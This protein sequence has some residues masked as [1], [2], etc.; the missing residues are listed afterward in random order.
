MS[1]SEKSVL[2][3]RDAPVGY[4]P[5]IFVKYEDVQTLDAALKPLTTWGGYDKDTGK[6]KGYE[7]PSS[8][9]DRFFNAVEACV[10]AG[11]RI[12]DANPHTSKE[13]WK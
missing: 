4:G 11:F 12:V 2:V 9:F 7:F 8:D 1:N 10:R 6:A 3:Y 13:F 5:R